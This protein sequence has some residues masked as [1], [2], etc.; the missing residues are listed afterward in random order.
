MNV[1]NLNDKITS[2]AP[3]DHWGDVDCSGVTVLDLGAGD[4]GMRHRKSYIS[5]VEHWLAL[6]A[7]DVVAVDMNMRD[8]VEIGSAPGSRVTMVADTI[9]HAAQI[10]HLL[11]SYLPAIVK[12]DIEGAE[13]LLRDVRRASFRIAEAWMVK[14]HTNE[15]REDVI[16]A[17][18]DHGFD[19]VRVRGHVN[20]DSFHVVYA[21]RRADG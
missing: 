14:T 13:C 1:L 15:L 21:S 17:L 5:T 16:V 3:A 8:L 19:V 4:F 10:N 6:G 18:D 11:E 7:K 9:H 2:E 20:S 12:V